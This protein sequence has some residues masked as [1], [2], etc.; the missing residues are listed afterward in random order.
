MLQINPLMENV[1]SPPGPVLA[2]VGPICEGDPLICKA[3]IL[4]F[5]TRGGNFSDKSKTVC[6]R[7]SSASLKFLAATGK[8]E[9][10]DYTGL[11]TTAAL[12]VLV[13]AIVF[14]ITSLTSLKI[15]EEN[16]RRRSTQR[17]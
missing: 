9:E 4:P 14:V 10:T 17:Q 12:I 8:N 2:K 5:V 7:L 11:I 15:K 13:V 16:I 1:D 3:I 6:R